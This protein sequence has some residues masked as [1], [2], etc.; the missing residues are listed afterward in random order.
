MTAIGDGAPSRRME[1]PVLQTLVEDRSCLVEENLWIF[2]SQDSRERQN[3]L[4]DTDRN[5]SSSTVSLTNDEK[6]TLTVPLTV[7][8]IRLRMK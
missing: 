5:S 1:E 8:G 4:V 6:N 2:S 7:I 3:A